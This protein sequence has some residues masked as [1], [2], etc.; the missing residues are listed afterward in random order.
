MLVEGKE[1][2]LMGLLQKRPGKTKED[3]KEEIESL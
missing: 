3:L 2:E 1:D